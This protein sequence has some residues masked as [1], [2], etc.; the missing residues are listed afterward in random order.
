MFGSSFSVRLLVSRVLH[1]GLYRAAGCFPNVMS[2]EPGREAGPAF[3]HPCGPFFVRGLS[4]GQRANGFFSMLG[5][6]WSQ[7]DW[8]W[9]AGLRAS[10]SVHA[11]AFSVFFFKGWR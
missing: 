1:R 3:L 10:L 2:S 4:L 9:E 5:D 6:W 7:E 8:C 11:N